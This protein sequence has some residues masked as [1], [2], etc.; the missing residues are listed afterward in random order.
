[1][2][3]IYNLLCNES[4]VPWLLFYLLN[5]DLY[6]RVNKYD[7]VVPQAPFG[8]FKMSGIGRDL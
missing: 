8:G 1:M 3:E 4:I 6:C 5:I 2:K 7:A